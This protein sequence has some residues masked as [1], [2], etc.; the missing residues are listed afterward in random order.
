MPQPKAIGLFA[1]LFL[2]TAPATLPADPASHRQAVERLFELTGMEQMIGESVSNITALQLSQSP[3]LRDHEAVVREFLER[4]IGW[5]SMQDALVDMYLQEFSEQELDEMN[6]FY[7]STTGQKVIQRLPVLVQMR[8]R[9]ASQRLQ[10]NIGELRY[11][12]DARM[13]RQEEAAKQQD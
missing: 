8:N 2:I 13:K 9:L 4:H 12:I 6:A 10:Q 5:Q 7:A 11:E 1:A 3:D